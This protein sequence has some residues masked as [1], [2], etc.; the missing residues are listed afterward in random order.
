M[1]LSF[2]EKSKIK[3]TLLTHIKSNPVRVNPLT[4]P[5]MLFSLISFR[6][7]YMVSSLAAVVLIIGST[8]AAQ[9]SLPGEAL[10]PVKLS[11]NENVESL[12]ALT[13]EDKAQVD[14]KQAER[15][16]LETESLTLSGN[17][18][19]VKT[20][21]IQQNFSKKVESL[22]KN[23]TKAK[24]SGKEKKANKVNEDFEKEID[25][26]YDAFVT[27]TNSASNS[28]TFASIFSLRNARTSGNTL[29]M[30]SAKVSNTKNTKEDNKKSSKNESS[31]DDDG[32]DDDEDERED[33]DDSRTI[34][35]PAT[36]TTQGTTTA[37]TTTN[38]TASYTLTDVSKHNKSTDCWTVVNKN[39]YNL[40]SWI[41]QHPGGQSAIIGLCG[42]DGTKL[43]TAQHGG[44]S[45]PESEL[46]SFKIGILK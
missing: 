17:L 8:L 28:P 10:Y 18:T 46:A 6:S 16:L 15:R 23:V 12:V 5:N 34:V 31:R 30:T 29:M 21:T 22:N 2:D 3:S 7:L 26:H 43:F 39:V 27:I 45:R 38:V 35:L 13:P 20:A 33:G 40:T 19:D 9:N 42:I 25:E 44:Q 11:F 14:L 24:Q 41:K 4:N 36:S 1:E 32:D 37:T